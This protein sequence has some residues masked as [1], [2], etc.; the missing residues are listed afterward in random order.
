MK[1]LK[2]KII[3]LIEYF[4]ECMEDE[5]SRKQWIAILIAITIMFGPFAIPLIF[6][7]TIGIFCIIYGGL[8]IW[9]I[10]SVIDSTLKQDR[11]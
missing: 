7:K 8:F 10:Y 2:N 6:P 5:G 9:F 4:L 11:N 1:K 3:S